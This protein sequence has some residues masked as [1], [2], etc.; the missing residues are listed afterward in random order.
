DISKHLT[1]LIKTGNMYD[2]FIRSI[3]KNGCSV[4]IKEKSRSEENLHTPSFFS[5]KVAFTDDV[6]VDPSDDGGME[7]ETG[8]EE[9]TE[10]EFEDNSND[11]DDSKE[12][13]P[14]DVLGEVLNH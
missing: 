14:L 3:S 8:N 11:D 1:N 2:C 12:S 5:A 7:N 9:A 13:I 10:V 6:L 4:F